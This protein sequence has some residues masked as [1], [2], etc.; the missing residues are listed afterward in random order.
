MHNKRSYLSLLLSS[1]VV[2]SC[3]GDQEDPHALD[4]EQRTLRD[5]EERL[6]SRLQARYGETARVQR[7]F[8]TGPRVLLGIALEEPMPESDVVPSVAV[9]AYDAE[10]D[11]FDL[12]TDE[13]TYR[14]AT[15]LGQHTALVSA[16]GELSLLA[17]DGS[18][19]PLLQG[20]RGDIAVS[21]DGR[22]LALTLG[23][24]NREHE[25]A[26]AVADL[27]G[28][29]AVIADAPGVDDRP[30]LSPDG[31]TLV[32]VSGR[33][34]IASCYRTTVHGDPPVQLTNVGI[35]AGVPRS[36][37]PP[38]FVPPPVVADRIEWLNDDVIRYDAG[39]GELW[40]LHVRTGLGAREGSVR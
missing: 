8:G 17:Q 29:V 1:L 30:T 19:R 27:E 7:V 28:N 3:G 31:E 13:A 23:A 4:A 2:V 18:Q 36:E 34:G 26:V 14:E 5:T 22:R 11:A 20:V 38:G 39:G 24:P 37:D 10:A 9:A 21:V 40:T 35:K 6:S 25:T 33:T 32:F 16:T 15:P 12:L